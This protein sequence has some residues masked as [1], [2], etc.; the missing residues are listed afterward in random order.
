ME[1]DRNSSLVVYT[2]GNEKDPFL[3]KLLASSRAN[4]TR[5]FRN[6]NECIMEVLDAATSVLLFDVATLTPLVKTHID[7]IRKEPACSNTAIVV[8]AGALEESDIVSLVGS[9][10]NHLALTFSSHQDLLDEINR[11]LADP[12]RGKRSSSS[13]ATLTQR[14]HKR[15]PR[16][17]SLDTPE[18]FIG[19]VARH[20]T[21][22]LY[23]NR[24]AENR[25]TF[26]WGLIPLTT[27]MLHLYAVGVEGPE[28]SAQKH[29]LRVNALV[30][31]PGFAGFLPEDAYRFI[32][33]TLRPHL[34]A[35]DRLRLLCGTYDKSGQ[36]LTY[37]SSFAQVT[38]STASLPITCDPVM[39]DN[40]IRIES[41]GL[42][43]HAPW[44]L[45][46]PFTGQATPHRQMA[47]AARPI[48]SH[49]LDTC[50]APL[51]QTRSW[52]CILFGASPSGYQSAGASRVRYA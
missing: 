35:S 11:L 39:A 12:R 4:D 21:L 48:A 38:T 14:I 25:E 23:Q 22:G 50:V 49:D 13:I 41:V 34:S 16:L 9:R 18:A 20:F 47:E 52:L 29:A 44:A 19:K 46:L 31:S 37:A 27:D 3:A 45:T 6:L 33:E 1:K 10:V 32:A 36:T 7:R 30:Q 17:G 5:V 15:L 2:E 28:I 43:I 8:R 26:T 40:A 24:P 51:D 42:T